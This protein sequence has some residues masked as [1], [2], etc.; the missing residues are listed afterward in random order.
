MELC[1]ECGASNDFS[2]AMKKRKKRGSRRCQSCSISDAV[3][4]NMLARQVTRR[5]HSTSKR[6]Y[7]PGHPGR[8]FE[9]SFCE[10]HDLLLSA[11]EDGTAGVWDLDSG[12]AVARLEHDV[13]NEVLRCDWGPEGRVAF[14]GGADGKAKVWHLSPSLSN[15]S[16]AATIVHDAEAADGDI[17]LYACHYLPSQRALLTG[18][19]HVVKLWD[20]EV[21]GQSRSGADKDQGLKWQASLTQGG[22]YNLG[23]AAK[24][25]DEQY[26]PI[27]PPLAFP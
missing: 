19:D 2:K 4:E 17:Q 20:V 10:S 25:P 11:S 23:G 9:V 27:T 5:L 6:E 24:N 8:I 13:N 18:G 3:P 15:P 7:L 16:C 12:S 26:V 21:A 14:T 22:S 1:I